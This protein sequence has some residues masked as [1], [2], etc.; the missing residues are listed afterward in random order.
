M[1]NF[2]YRRSIG[3]G[4]RLRRIAESIPTPQRRQVLV[5]LRAVS[6]NFRDNLIS[7]GRNFRGPVPEN[8]IPLSDG[9]G[10]I[11][12]VGSD[13]FAWHVGDRVASTFMPRWTAGNID[14]YKAAVVTGTSIDGVLTHWQIF[15]DDAIVR[16]PDHL[17]WHEAATLPCAALTGWSAVNGVVPVRAGETVLVLGTGG[18]ALFAAQFAGIAGA[19]VILTS[20]SKAKLDRTKALGVTDT[21]NYVETPDWHERVLELTDGAGADHVVETNGPGTFE[22]SMA[23]CRMGGQ[24]YAIGTQSNGAMVD[25]ALVLKARVA[26]RS[27]TVGSHEAFAQMN[28]SLSTHPEIRPVV[29]RIFSFDEAEDALAYLNSGSHFGKVV[30]D[31]D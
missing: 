13:V 28:R 2:S 21:I 11:E 17:T 25:G 10:T 3:D 18:V 1:T 14:R 31:I 7:A 20:S 6:I 29:D 22:Q 16:V 24:I 26:L 8:M 12:A 15:D 27:V 5:R 4:G 9:V 23:A 19:R 30:I